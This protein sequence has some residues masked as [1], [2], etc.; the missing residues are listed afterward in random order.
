[1]HIISPDPWNVYSTKYY[2]ARFDHDKTRLPM[3]SSN[4]C[5]THSSVPK[6]IIPSRW[7]YRSVLTYA[8]CIRRCK[9]HTGTTSLHQNSYA[10]ISLKYI[11]RCIHSQ[12]SSTKLIWLNFK[13]QINFIFPPTHAFIEDMRFTYLGLLVVSALNFYVYIKYVRWIS[14]YIFIFYSYRTFKFTCLGVAAI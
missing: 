14:S 6:L 3:S 1:M 7:K 4:V 10:G 9:L 12:S 11:S 8:S 13:R 5:R 2:K